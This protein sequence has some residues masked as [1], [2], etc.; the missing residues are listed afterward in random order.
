MFA[1]PPQIDATVFTEIPAAF[2]RHEPNEWINIQFH[3]APMPTFLEGP[4]FDAEGTLWV[5]DIPWG[6]LFKISPSGEVTLGAEYDGQP[7]GLKFL[8]DGR[9]LIADH[10]HGLMLLDPIRGKVEPYI[11]RHLL[12]P[13]KGCNDLTVAQNGDVYFT[14]MGQT[15]L[16]D[17]TGRLFRLRADNGRLECLLDNIPSPNGLVIN[18]A[19]TMLYLAVTRMNAVWKVPLLP[20]G[21]ISK[22]GVFVYLSGGT[23]GPDGL[24]IDENDNLVVCH[25]GFGAV[26]VFNPRGEPI[27]RIESPRGI[28]T[29]NCAFGGP[30]NKTLFITE[31]RTGAILTA[32]MP[33]PGRQLYLRDL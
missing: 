27:L 4:C 1:A 17:P 15:G 9:G 2:G 22:V 14:D 6:R 10:H 11:T 23:S 28:N 24:A 32:P 7:N 18:K 33:A 12:E 3:G 26:W 30:D 5:T 31:S 29:T 8:K 19:E 20:G 13:F 25:N 16:H 21:D